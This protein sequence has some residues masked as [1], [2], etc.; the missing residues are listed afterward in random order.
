M[1]VDPKEGRWY[2]AGVDGPEMI[3]LPK[4]AIV[5]NAKQTEDLLN[6]G[7]T[8]TRGVPAHTDGTLQDYDP[9]EDEMLDIPPEI[10]GNAFL[11]GNA[12][13]D[14]TTAAKGG[15]EV[16]TAQNQKKGG[17]NKSKSE[18]TKATKDNTKATKDNTDKKKKEGQVFDWVAARLSYLADVTASFADAITDFIT[19]EDK[20]VNL[21]GKFSTQV[22]KAG[23]ALNGRD[24]IGRV[25]GGELQA[26]L[27]EIVEN[28]AGAVRYK[29]EANAVKNPYTTANTKAKK[30]ANE[31][32]GTTKAMIDSGYIIDIQT[33]KD[34]KLA[35]AIQDYQSYS[36]SARQAANNVA[37]LNRQL[38]ELYDTWAKAP[39]EQAEKQIQRLTKGIN[40]LEAAEARIDAISKGGST[41]FQLDKLLGK[42][43]SGNYS[44]LGGAGFSAFASNNASKTAYYQKAFEQRTTE[45]NRTIQNFRDF[46]NQQISAIAKAQQTLTNETEV[47]TGTNSSKISKKSVKAA[48]KKVA[49]KYAKT[50]SA[51][52][53]KSLK[54]GKKTSTKKL[55]GKA[56]KAVVQQNNLVKAYNAQISA[57][58]TGQKIAKK[59]AKSLTAKQKKALKSGKTVSTKGVKNKTLKKQLKSY[60]KKVKKKSAAKSKVTT[61]KVRTATSQDVLTAQDTVSAAQQ[62]FQAFL[63][64]LDSADTDKITA[65]AELAAQK[66]QEIRDNFD[67][68]NEAYQTQI[69]YQ[70]SLNKLNERFITEAET[71]GNEITAQQRTAQQ[72]NV[73][74][75][76]ALKER[77]ANSL[78][79][80]LDAG[81]TAGTIKKDSKEWLEMTQQINEAKLAAHEYGV[82]IKQLEIKKLED[83]ADHYGRILDYMQSIVDLQNIYNE[84][85]EIVGNYRQESY[86]AQQISQQE[87]I[88]NKQ[89]EQAT[90]IQLEFWKMSS[91]QAGQNGQL[92]P[93]YV[94]GSD[95]YI[96]KQAEINKMWKQVYDSENAIA[97]LEAERI[98]FEIDQFNRV[99]QKQDTFID[100]LNT[101]SGLISD[102][103]KWDYDTGDLTT[104]GQLTMMVDKQ[105]FN[106]AL[107][108]IQRVAEQKQKLLE[109][110]RTDASYGQ[111][112]F[113]ED[114]KDLTSKQ[115]SYLSSAKS[116]LESF[117][118]T[119]QTTARK[120]LDALNKVIDKRKE[121]LQKEQEYYNYD[122][123][124][125]NQTKDI[126]LLEA[127]SRALQ[128]V[129]DAESKAMKARLDAQ[130]AQKREAMND[131]V[132]EHTTTLQ[133]EGLSDLQNKMQQNYERWSQQFEANAA[134]Q[135]AV[136][137]RT[138]MS[139][140]QM[141]SAMDTMLST[142]GTNMAQMGM[143]V[144]TANM[145]TAASVDGVTAAFN[146]FAA[147]HTAY[148]LALE[149]NR[150]AQALETQ[151][152]TGPVSDV[153]IDKNTTAF[154]GLTTAGEATIVQNMM[155]DSTGDAIRDNIATLDQTANKLPGD[156]GT[157]ID[158][159]IDSIDAAVT[160]VSKSIADNSSLVSDDMTTAIYNTN[161]ILMG[162]IS[163]ILQAINDASAQIAS[164]TKKAA[165]KGKSTSQKSTKKSTKSST[166]KAKTSSSK[167]KK[168]KTGSKKKRLGTLSINKDDIYLTQEDGGEIITTKEGVL[169][170]L[171]AGDG[172]I[173]AQLTEKLFQMAREYPSAPTTPGIE[174]PNLQTTGNRS[175]VSVTYGSLLTVNGN[176]DKEILPNLKTI[177]QESYSYTQKRLAQDAA[178]AGMRKKY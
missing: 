12:Y 168:T 19:Y 142:F 48:G 101:M 107:D 39:A 26:L 41:Q 111:Q 1:Y 121:A 45:L 175:N 70:E 134:Q 16:S 32:F 146:A 143:Q 116:S 52:Q 27:N 33:I 51:S 57:K 164:A 55:K 76:K 53:E 4:D 139:S 110:L 62:G 156:V 127:Q 149:A 73:A 46:Q 85:D 8:S 160:N 43:T 17:D 71:F 176:V 49:K 83:I 42:S 86:Y 34:E 169:V 132:R 60:N 6:K 96:A 82:E 89:R 106:S 136:M 47:I 5:F 174:I 56:K 151:A 44:N 109:R 59:Y 22:D 68:I 94:K 80:Q 81:V 20:L 64:A 108:E 36:D 69:A 63:D 144:S 87:A 84:R 2:T 150:D 3:D 159:E 75:N 145:A 25:I 166:S 104:Q 54:S 7:Y 14:K 93:A 40:G 91:S 141:A 29:Q 97:K 50:L 88:R 138:D 103:S 165:S 117:T 124:L 148:D 130:I 18:N 74:V 13:V 178:K 95:A 65:A 115:M 119:V 102:A 10:G 61:T 58:T 173:P 163:S 126:A 15:L 158:T 129:S 172:V 123:Q 92:G 66:V 105:S 137:Q 78:Q 153:V 30:A 38:V 100:N 77:Q 154:T 11:S 155:L 67:Y 37:N 171:K 162:G 72:Q 90:K 118:K 24:S 125:K 177:L 135:L 98:Q 161:A 120:Q 147:D 170:P 131:S 133:T 112:A 113:D 79:K 128:N 167:S 157:K 35:K 114:L 23:K 99:L 9:L 21:V 122:K 152:W 140:A 31:K 28:R